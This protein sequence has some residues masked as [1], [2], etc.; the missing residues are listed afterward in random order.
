MQTNKNS[1]ISNDLIDDVYSQL[2]RREIRMTAKERL[3]DFIRLT[4]VV[5]DLKINWFPWLAIIITTMTFVAIEFIGLNKFSGRKI[6]HAFG[7]SGTILVLAGT[8]WMALGAFLNEKE[9]EKLRV[10]ATNDKIDAKE[11]VRMLIAN[12]NFVS[13]GAMFILVASILL[14]ID[15]LVE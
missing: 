11:L 14:V 4:N 2:S 15:F 12:S 8:F 3:R 13:T 7:V 10:M 9:K 5:G 6:N 1:K